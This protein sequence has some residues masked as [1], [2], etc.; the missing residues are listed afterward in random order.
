MNKVTVSPKAGD[1]HFSLPRLYTGAR[2][3]FPKRA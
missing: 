3:V 1:R 2:S